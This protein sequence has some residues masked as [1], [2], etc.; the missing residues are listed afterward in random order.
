MLLWPALWNRYPIVFA[1]TGTYLSQA[2]HHYAGWDRPVFYSLFILPLHATVTLWPV[3]AVQAL[4]AVYVLALTCRVFLCG[5]LSAAD[6]AEPPPPSPLWRKRARHPRF[7]L[8]HPCSTHCFF[9]KGIGRWPA[10]STPAA[11]DDPRGKHDRRVSAGG[12]PCRSA[13]LSGLLGIALLTAL[14]WLPFLV[15]EVMPDLF[16]PLLILLMTVLAWT[17]DRISA[18]ERWLLVPVAAFMTASQQ[19]SLPLALVLAAGLAALAVRLRHLR[20]ALLLPA[21]LVPMLAA[22]ALCGMNLAAHHRFSL[23][24]YG[25]V[26]YLA[27]LIADGPVSTELA[28]ACPE[29]GWRLCAY[30]DRLPMDSDRFLWTSDSPLNQA[31]GPKAMA[32]EAGRILAET[33]RHQP[34]RVLAAALADTGR[35]LG[36]FDSGDGLEP[37]AKQVTPWMTDDFPVREVERYDRA[38]QQQGQLALPAWLMITHRITALA[39]VAAC[40]ILLPIAWRRRSLTLGLLIAVLC[41]LPLSAAVT[42]VLSGP[43]GRYQSRIMWLPVFATLLTVGSMAPFRA[44]LPHPAAGKH[45]P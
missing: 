44:I 29:A 18:R 2:V 12:Y 32:A 14:T 22:L 9:K 1:D 15:S 6:P 4:I 8:A 25:S 30:Q 26:F 23:S 21:L 3:V 34:G 7:P 36:Q 40:V 28:H 13:Y 10:P 17:P 24:P 39:G 27:R 42:G 38:R 43:H 5:P 16:T 45:A 11:D 33:L 19:S 35:Q 37:W 20:P 31:G 41:V